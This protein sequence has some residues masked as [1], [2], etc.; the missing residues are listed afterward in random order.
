MLLFLPASMHAS[1]CISFLIFLC[2][3]SPSKSLSNELICDYTPFPSFCNSMRLQNNFGSIQEY[4]RFILQQS[5]SSTQN[6][7]SIING[8]LQ[9]RI[10]LQEYT[11]HALEDCQLLTS[12]NIDFFVKTLETIK[13]A[14]TIDGPT[15]SDLLSLLSATLTNYQTCLDGLEAITPLSSIKIAL[16]TPLSDGNMLNSVALAIFKYGWIPSAREGR[17][18]EDRKPLDAGLKLYPGGNTVNVSQSVVVNPNGSGDFTTITGAVAAAPNNTD[19]SDGYFLIYIAAGVYEEHVYIAKSK[20][21]LMMIG[22]GIDK[23]IITGN[24]SVVDG[25]TTFNTATFGKLS[26]IYIVV[27]TYFRI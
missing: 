17:I 2:F 5:I 6:V 9:L 16:R 1:T 22:D 11:F 13:F 10:G 27:L 3:F 25:W 24:R 14:D 7:L 26:S 21:Y 19:C 4:G 12:L 8:Y 15:A 20:R 18:L 23:T